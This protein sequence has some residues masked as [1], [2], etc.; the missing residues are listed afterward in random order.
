[1]SQP[2]PPAEVHHAP[3]LPRRIPP[4]G[5]PKFHRYVA[6]VSYGCVGIISVYNIFFA[7]Y[8]EKEHV[9]SPARR[10]LDR[11]KSAFWTLSPTEQAAAERVRQQQQVLPHDNSRPT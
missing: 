7:D 3:P 6:I 9:F 10:W 1:M 8:G 11:Q 5:Q 2:P 4:A